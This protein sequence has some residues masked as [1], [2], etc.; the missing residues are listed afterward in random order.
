MHKVLSVS[1]N[2]DAE[3]SDGS[4]IT[5]EEN[6]CATEEETNNI[7]GDENQRHHCRTRLFDLVFHFELV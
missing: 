1:H 2:S 3:H 7:T 6:Q 4:D 5:D